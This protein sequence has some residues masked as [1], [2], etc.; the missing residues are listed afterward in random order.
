MRKPLTI[1]PTEAAPIVI[2]FTALALLVVAVQH[3]PM[4]WWAWPVAA[5]LC[6]VAAWALFQRDK[7]RAARRNDPKPNRGPAR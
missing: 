5:L 6:P 7:R 4:P 3:G 1:T 2:L